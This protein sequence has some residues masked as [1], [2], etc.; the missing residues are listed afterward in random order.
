MRIRLLASL[1]VAR[2]RAAACHG[3]GR[4][5]LRR[6]RPVRESGR[7]VLE[8]DGH[9]HRD[10]VASSRNLRLP[11]DASPERSRDVRGVVGKSAGRSRRSGH[12]GRWPLVLLRAGRR[13]RVW[14]VRS[15]DGR[16]RAAAHSRSAD[17]H[18]ARQDSSVHRR[19]A[20]PSTR[21][22]ASTTTTSIAMGRRSMRIRSRPAVR[23]PGATSWG[24]RPVRSPSPATIPTPWWPLT[25]RATNRT[26]RIRESS[27]PISARP[28]RRAAPL[29]TAHVRTPAITFERVGRC[30]RP[31]H[32]LGRQP[33][34]RLPTG[35]QSQR[36]SDPRGRSACME[37][38]GWA[39]VGSGGR[40][41]Q[42]RLHDRR[43]RLGGE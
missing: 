11:S 23:S 3:A 33:L 38:R 18:I 9:V 43:R 41:G 19:S 13:A 14:H 31:R 28:I 10:G 25:T 16:Y 39:V 4:D 36:Q 12:A 42:L 2:R 21:S 6:L 30:S 24:S 37:R 8:R 17:G 20:R 32:R 5:H 7:P 34:R 26:H 22:P 15:G 40:L 1:V 29:G 27:K 35:L